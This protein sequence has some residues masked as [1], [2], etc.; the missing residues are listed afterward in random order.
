MVGCPCK[1]FFR[2]DNNPATGYRYVG[3]GTQN[4][5]VRQDTSKQ[6]VRGIFI[7]AQS[8][9]NKLNELKVLLYK[10]EFDLVCI[11]ETCCNNE[12]VHQD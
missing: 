4:E 2:I 9:L 1:F 11:N 3:N 12:H 7:N 5:K 10:E 6:N 8:I